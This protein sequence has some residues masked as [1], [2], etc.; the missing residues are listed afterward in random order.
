MSDDD[1]PVLTTP[2]DV[3]PALEA[4]ASPDEAGQANEVGAAEE[5]GQT[6]EQASHSGGEVQAGGT[7]EAGEAGDEAQAADAESTDPEEGDT[8]DGPAESRPRPAYR[9]PAFAILRAAVVVVISVV[10]Y[11]AVVPSTVVVRARLSRLVV[12][13]PGLSGF[14]AKPAQSAEQPASQTNLKTLEAAAKQAPNKTGAYAVEWTKSQAAAVAVFAYL[15]PNDAQAAA[16]LPEVKTSQMAASSFSAEGLTRHTT[17]SVKGIPGSSGALYTSSAKT[18]AAMPLAVTAFRYGKVVAVT[19]AES[20]T[21]AQSNA[22]T[23]ASNEYAHLQQI[24]PGFTLS[25][26]R[27]PVGP[28][29]LWAIGT[30]LLALIVAFEPIVRRRRAARRQRRFEEEQSHLLVVGGQ[31]ISKHRR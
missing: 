21:G 15:L 24:E 12:T 11:Q 10:V 7:E 29:A 23:L 3:D 6:S 17:F 4:Q 1:N 2:D 19:E 25:V 30:G 16:L 14:N 20:S 13:E 31:T 18:A 26:V 28:T 27:R 9:A 22:E 8:D 5:V